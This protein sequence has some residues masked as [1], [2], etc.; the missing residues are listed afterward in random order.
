MKASLLAGAVALSLITTPRTSSP[1]QAPTSQSNYNPGPPSSSSPP[2]SNSDKTFTPLDAYSEVDDKAT[3]DE[4]LKEIAAFG[5]DVR[6]EATK[7]EP[8]RTD[9]DPCYRK[10]AGEVNIDW[11][12]SYFVEFSNV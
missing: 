9:T 6:R 10:T 5:E 7:R 4:L 8:L 3:F 12:H 2:Q 11:G 1:P